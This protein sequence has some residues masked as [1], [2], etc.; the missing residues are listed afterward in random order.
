MPHVML[1]ALLLMHAKE[2]HVIEMQERTEQLF[3]HFGECLCG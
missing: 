3:V 2:A 1:Q